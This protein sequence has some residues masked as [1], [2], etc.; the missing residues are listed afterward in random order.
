[1][2]EDNWITLRKI[3]RELKNTHALNADHILDLLDEVGEKGTPYIG[4][5]DHEQ[6]ELAIGE[7]FDEDCVNQNDVKKVVSQFLTDEIRS[8]FNI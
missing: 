8:K 2:L 6:Y 3:I 7:V 1:M 5:W 4:S